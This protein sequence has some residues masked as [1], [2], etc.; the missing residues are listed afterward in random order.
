L[1][2]VALLVQY[3]GSHY[4]GWQ[5]QK[6]ATTVQEILDSALLKITNHTVNT[7]AAGRTDAGVHGSWNQ[8]RLKI[9]GMHAIQ[10]CIGIIDMLSIIVNSLTCLSIIGHGIDIKK[11]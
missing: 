9:L 11:Y 2:R 7:F 4:S 5:K 8:L 1:K 3:D 6:N 10:Q